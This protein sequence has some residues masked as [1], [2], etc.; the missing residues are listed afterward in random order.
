MK[1]LKTP[2]NQRAALLGASSLLECL[3]DEDKYTLAR[4]AMHVEFEKDDIL[5]AQDTPAEGFY[6]LTKGRVKVFRIGPEGRE[7]L[8]HLFGRGEML[9]EVPVFQGRNYPA[10][11]Q[12]QSTTQAVYIPGSAFLDFAENNPQ[13][14]IEMLAVLSHRLRRFVELV[15]DL[16]L[17]EVSA[18]LAKYLLDHSIRSGSDTF[19]LDIPKTTLA[20][21]L[22]TIPE[23]LS[24]TLK[25]MQ[26][27]GLIAVS[28]K[29]ITL[30]DTQTLLAA[31]SGQKL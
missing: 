28:D 5:F 10:T 1:T 27:R 31:A 4:A 8:L 22:G 15:D 16:S 19:T 2:Q 23:T 21:R 12:A 6:I 29:Q 7:Q 24:R 30:L 11:A 17:K 18:R 14:L 25:K 3:S 13:V 20:S 9:G 26:D